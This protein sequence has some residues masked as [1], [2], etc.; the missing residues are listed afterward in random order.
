MT[1]GGVAAP[2]EATYTGGSPVVLP[3]VNSAG[4]LSTGI[5]TDAAGGVSASSRIPAL[6]VTLPGHGS[7][8]AAAAS[9]SCVFNRKT[10]VV[11][12]HSVIIGGHITRP[13][14]GP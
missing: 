9:S 3:N 13:A 14:S 8:R 11:T 2:R 6:A 1:A 10:R 12:S 4:L 7:L 5:I